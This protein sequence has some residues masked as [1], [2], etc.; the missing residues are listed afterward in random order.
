MFEKTFQGKEFKSETWRSSKQRC[1]SMEVV[2]FKQLFHV[3]RNFQV[4]EIVET[5]ESSKL[6]KRNISAYRDIRSHE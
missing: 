6:T 4:V 3:L 2:T 5:L 1:L